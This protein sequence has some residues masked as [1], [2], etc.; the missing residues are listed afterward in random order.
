MPGAVR[1]RMESAF[2]VGFGQVRLHTDARAGRTAEQLN[3]RAFTV[4][5]H[6]A[7]NT[8]EYQP[9]SLVGQALLAHELAHVVQQG[10]GEALQRHS[11][12]AGEGTE[13]LEQ[14]ADTAAVSAVVSI[15]TGARK[16]LA[17]V[18]QG[19][20]PRLKSG[21]RLQR[22]GR[23]DPVPKATPEI[24][25]TE[26]AL[27]AHAVSCMIAANKGPHTRDSGVWYAQGYESAFPDEWE[28]DYAKGYANP[29]Y[30][31]RIDTYQWRLKK[32]RSASAGVKAW[33][34][35]LTI[36][37][38]YATA[39]VSEVDAVR[40]GI[41]D[42]KFDE[43]FGSEDT[44]G[45]LLL[46]LGQNGSNALSDGVLRH[47]NDPDIGTIGNRPAVVGEW[48][49]FYNH[50]QYL[51]KHPAG[52]YQGENAMLRSDRA[53][54]GDQLWEGLGQKKVTERQMYMN[55]MADY[56]QPR[57]Q[58][59]EARLDGIRK[60]NGGKLPAAY[61]LNSGVF[62]ERLASYQDI[63]D[64]PPYTI[65]GKERKGGYNPGARKNLDPDKVQELKD[66]P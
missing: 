4:G 2:G 44:P 30:W 9:D 43:L 53:P 27:G 57:T 28:K 40:A 25:I 8:G 20:M 23:R 32:G 51:L 17:K 5:S 15:A 66:M 24:P 50:P 48:H 37:E 26:E 60:A 3:A 54:N 45:G 62:P 65:R 11:R 29:D 33:L 41:G 58:W 55:M 61:D 35:G 64:A 14:D 46:E 52:V 13:A 16:G 31:E 34:K 39:I 42:A 12:A 59:D 1:S 6:V 10:R 22:C 19:A 7:F 38:C 47:K 49:Y 36:A 63:L 18:A 56:N 21:L